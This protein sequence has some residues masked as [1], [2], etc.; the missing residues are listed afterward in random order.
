MRY[1]TPQDGE[2]GGSLDEVEQQRFTP[3]VKFV[4]C[5]VLEEGGE[6][7][8]LQGWVGAGQGIEN[9]DGR[10]DGDGRLPG[11]DIAPAAA[12]GINP[13]ARSAGIAAI[14]R[15]EE[16]LVGDLEEELGGKS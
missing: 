5:A 6:K 14:V 3:R 12:F 1:E 2:A 15:E 4:A 8:G 13:F 11:D 10:D 7:N 16:D 9:F